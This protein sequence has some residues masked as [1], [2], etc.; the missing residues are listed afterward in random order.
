M[1]LMDELKKLP[2]NSLGGTDKS[3]IDA[4]TLQDSQGNRF[5]IQGVDAG[6][7]EKITQKEGYSLGT[8]GGQATTEIVRGLA[9]EQGF[10]NLVPQ[11]GPDGQPIRDPFGRIIADLTNDKGESFKS[12]LLKA[13][14]FDVNQYTTQQDIAARDI[15]EA[16]RRQQQ[17]SGDYTENAFD[18]AANK[19]K[20]AEQA[21]H[22]DTIRFKQT[23]LNEAQLAAA[24]AQGQGHLYSRDTVGIRHFDRDLNNKAN[25]PF[26]D[27]WEQ[28]WIGVGEAAFG[29]AN[30]LGEE[31]GLDGVASWGEDGVARQQA[32]LGDYGRTVLDY[33]DVDGLGSAY[34]YLGNNLAL[35][36]PYMIGITAS[37]AA[38]ALAAPVVG[39]AGALAIGVGAPATIYT[40]QVWNEMEG[41]KN[42]GVAIAAGVTQAAL[43][44]LGISFILP[45]GVGTKQITNAAVDA[46][47]KSGI[48]REAAKQSLVAATRREIAGL[49]GDV[50]KIAKSQLQAKAIGMDLLKRAG[51][52]AAGESLTEVGQEAIGYLAA[53]GGSD[54]EFDWHDL[55]NRLI[56]AAIAGGSLGG[57]LSV[58]S[59]VYNA[60]AWADV[61]YRLDT[62]TA[63]SASQGEIYSNL[64]KEQQGRVASTEELAA[65]ARARYQANPG[66]TIEERAKAYNE[67][68]QAKSSLDRITD[69]AT[70]VSSLWQ[71]A[72]RN[73]FTPELQSKSRSARILADLFGGNLQRIFH[74]S[75]FENAKHHRVA[76]Y[77][78]MVAD[79]KSFY[80]ALGATRRSQKKDAGDVI[81]SELNAAVDKDGNFDPNK[82]P[83]NSKN[84]N[85]II[86]L[87]KQLQQLGDRMHADQKKHNPKLGY[88]KNYLFKYKALN[89]GAVHKNQRKFVEL[90]RSEY[91][92]DE[93]T[94]RAIT[95]AIVD[96]PE[97]ADIDEAFSVVKGGIVPAS[98]KKRALGLSEKDAFKEF[99]ERDIFSNVSQA[100]KSA[101]RYTAHRDF[102]GENGAVV[103]KLLDDMQ[104]E[105]VPEA[106]VDKVA[107]QLQNYLDAESGNYKRP[108]SQVGK[109]FQRIQKNVMMMTTLAGLPLAVISSFV[110]YALSHSALR[111]D[112]IFGKEGSLSST[113]KTAANMIWGGFDKTLREKD[114][115]ARTP[116]EILK[117]LGFYDW[118][119]GAAT[120]T[121][122]TEINSWQQPVYEL[123][124]KYNGLQDW[125]NYTRALRASMAGDYM[126]DKAQTIGD[127]KASGEPR[128]REVQEAEEA[129]RNLGLDVD[130]FVDQAQMQ[131]AGIPLDPQVEE[132]FGTAMREATFNFINNAVALPQSA[133][134][135]LIYQD[136]RFALFTQFQ[137]FIATFT[138]NHIPKLWGEYVKRG[139]PAMKYNAFA[140]MATM[141]MLGFASQHL[142]DLIKYAYDEEEKET[143]ANP[144]LERAEYLQRGVRASGLFG[145]GERVLD[146]FFPIYEQRSRGVGDWAW[147]QVS[148]ESPGISYVERVAKGLGHFAEGDPTRGTY[149]ILK[150][151]PGL[152]PFTSVDRGLANLITTGGWKPKGE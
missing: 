133:N 14:A 50:Q 76:V 93:T 109:K 59:S 69:A 134:R 137:G 92:M 37:T 101:A 143:G 81:Y 149:N 148:G 64:E 144:Y 96:N 6:E 46:M 80:Q 82:I 139:T 29:F 115:K 123:F 44:R 4:D 79:P 23:A 57:G 33:T 53:T 97:V 63:G 95:D 83:E 127:W 114:Y 145:T 43:D 40:G 136:P 108:T 126:I 68:K 78:N 49:A 1:G 42:A 62:E 100:V 86:Q 11:I 16:N 106:E 107:A 17:L 118:D 32:K 84:R 90:L 70:N 122:V 98:H 3:F 66:A 131:A 10:T 91:N 28:G 142:K 58:P 94:A 132:Q 55:N 130:T 99:M 13:G 146:L 128:T 67:K 124:F 48:P 151:T 36:L 19:I 5:R 152:G 21:D 39:T 85:E 75:N 45:K 30:L 89:K 71:G 74:G 52:G 24:K 135:P 113:G 112:Q 104:A 77:K 60:G 2:P 27:S 41:E 25:N 26:S 117:D 129:L 65:D 56:S 35:S 150:A 20:D 103:N 141:I 121:G 140:T 12:E 15:A 54:K 61:A 87:A 31:L 47:V 105:G 119:V 73:I 116:G 18:N 38:G 88:I 51:V 8:E 72:T 9:N 22:V 110:E 120:T 125:T 111:K 147:N 34:E 138:A 102:I 7:V